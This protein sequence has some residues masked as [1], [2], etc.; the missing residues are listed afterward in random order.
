MTAIEFAFF[1]AGFALCNL[2]YATLLLIE[3]W[4]KPK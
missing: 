3:E 1:A 4:R 2:I